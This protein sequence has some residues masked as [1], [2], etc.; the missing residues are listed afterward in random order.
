[1]PTPELAASLL[2]EKSRPANVKFELQAVEDIAASRAEGRYIARDVEYV[3]VKAQGGVDTV[4]YK[5]ATWL[6]RIEDD[7]RAYRIPWSW[8]EQWKAQLEAWRKK[9]DIPLFG[10]PI[11]GWGVISP[12][13]QEMLLHMDVRTVEDLAK[14]NDEA[15]RRYGMGAID[16][17]N[18]ATAWLSQTAEKGPLTQE[19]AALKRDN[20]IKNGQITTLMRQVDELRRMVPT[21]TTP[22]ASA[23][24]PSNET[25]TAQSIVDRARDVKATATHP[26]SDEI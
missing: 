22:T 15:L 19:L 7:A 8:V 6:Q 18:K 14:M 24:V 3:H 4:S 25:V 20:E 16:M 17:K 26:A 23:Q 11:K 10:T 21:L 5:V 13:Q 1:M 9:Q 12:A 2:E